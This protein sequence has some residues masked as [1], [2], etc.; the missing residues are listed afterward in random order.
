MP[1]L[2]FVVATRVGLC[3]CKCT[4]EGA[5]VLATAEFVSEITTPKYIVGFG[6]VITHG[7]AGAVLMNCKKHP[8]VRCARS[9]GIIAASWTL[10]GNFL[11]T[12][13]YVPPRCA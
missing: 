6:A 11:M 5:A 13:A 9:N 7:V 4:G 10:L 2:S 1:W 3:A 12:L 8:F